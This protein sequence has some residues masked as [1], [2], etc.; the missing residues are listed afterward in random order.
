MKDQKAGLQ[1]KHKELLDRK[2][3]IEKL[4][5]EVDK[6]VRGDAIFLL[7][8]LRDFVQDNRDLYDQFFVVP[9]STNGKYSVSYQKRR[10]GYRI[11]YEYRYG[12]S[13]E[14][15]VMIVPDLLIESP[16]KYKLVRIGY[17][18]KKEID[19]KEKFKQGEIQ[20]AREIAK[21]YGY[22]LIE[23]Y[24]HQARSGYGATIV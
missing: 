20:K 19:A 7:E 3:E 14:H 10:K 11:S 2:L 17:L 9:H 16:L 8:K 21:K 12:D 4:L 23:K 5:E 6:E 22:E 24:S 1:G 18:K 13:T 15:I